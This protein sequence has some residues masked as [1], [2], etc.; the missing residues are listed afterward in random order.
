MRIFVYENS[1]PNMEIY[2]R[3]HMQKM[4]CLSLKFFN[5]FYTIT[6]NYFF[7]PR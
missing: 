4:L 1:D 2:I 7:V 5:A 3:I 6:L